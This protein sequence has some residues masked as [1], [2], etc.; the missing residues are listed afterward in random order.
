M[1][2]EGRQ[3]AFNNLYKFLIFLLYFTNMNLLW[4]QVNL[5]FVRDVYTGFQFLFDPFD[6]F[7]TIKSMLSIVNSINNVVGFLCP[8]HNQSV[9]AFVQSWFLLL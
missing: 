6:I 9:F 8:V 5:P 2:K 7:N 3:D 4:P 1:S